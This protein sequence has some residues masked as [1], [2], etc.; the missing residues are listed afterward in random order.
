MPAT[1]ATAQLP[2]V[3][4]L[5]ALGS[6]AKVATIRADA[7]PGGLTRL[8]PAVLVPER[9]RAPALAICAAG[10]LT[11][12]AGMTFTTHPLFRWAAVGFFAMSTYALVDLRRR[13]PDV[14]CGCFGEVSSRPIGVR[15]IGRTVLLTAMSAGTLAYPGIGWAAM[16]GI[17]WTM[18][19]CT[20]VGLA[21]LA[22]L[23]PELE[24][25]V[26]RLRHRAPCEQRPLAPGTALARL[27]AS[28][29]WDDHRMLLTGGEPV[30]TW[31]ELCWRFF[32]FAGRT[33]DGAPVDVV[34]AVYLSGRRPP[35]RAAVVSA[36]GAP[37][38]P[39][40]ESIAVS[41]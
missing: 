24:E 33:P 5:L 20:A 17:T 41:A 12:A 32:A 36:D 16:S 28:T 6:A 39:L 37:V 3:V 11:L 21:L 9:W 13:R 22:A 34:F 8:G 35:V 1:V 18:A 26:A 14:G 25:A 38:E 40:R 2:L 15:S 4:L 30:D 19:G 31:R 23:S 27:R 29:A 7:E 10:E